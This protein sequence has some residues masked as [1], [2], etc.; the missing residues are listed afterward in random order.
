M[1]SREIVLWVDDRWYDALARRLK[2]ETVEDKL[3]DYLDMLVNQLPRQEYER[4][5]QEIYQEEQQAK[6]EQEA[7]VNSPCSIFGR[8]ARNTIFK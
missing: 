7:A 4:I 1:S 6:E 5:S 8:A 3:N 2:D